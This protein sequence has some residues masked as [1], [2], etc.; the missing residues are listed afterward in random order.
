MSKKIH[1]NKFD[2][3]KSNYLGA[4]KPIT[5]TCPIHG[6][7][8]LKQSTYHISGTG[9]PKCGKKFIKS[10][11]EFIKK[12]KEIHGDKYDYSKVEYN[13]L[14]DP[15]TIICPIHGE[16]MQTPRSHIQNK[17]NCPKCSGVGKSNT[18]EFIEKSKKIHGSNYDYSKV[19]YKGNKK[20]VT[21]ICKKHGE[22]F[23]KP[24]SHLT[25]MGCP[26]CGRER[27]SDALSMNTDE[28]INSAKEIHG[29]KYDYS[30]VDYKNATTPIKIICP[31]HGEFEQVPYYHLSGNG[32]KKCGAR[33]IPYTTREYISA[34]KEIHG[35]K[36]DYSNTE[37]V[38]AQTPI[39]INCKKHGEFL[40]KPSYHL[41]GHGCPRCSESKGQSLVRQ[42]LN[43]NSVPFVEEKRFDDCTNEFEGRYCIK[44]P[45]DFYVE[46]LNTIIEY[47][48]IQHYLPSFGAK[49]FEITQRNDKLKNSYCKRKKINLIRIPYTLSP[50][51]VE[52]YLLSKLGITE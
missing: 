8:E 34:A 27:I 52:V 4:T 7:F 5:I 1:G 3:S 36:F 17:A 29:D 20:P 28:F 24:N 46:S 18:F 14:K 23:Q 48:G 51:E 9:C 41:S 44:L 19:E 10:N 47:D 22:F 37:Y 30:E 38:N 26:K 25:G 45:F 11:D 21:I 31:T 35:D 6:D 15:V 43:K 40:Q 50:E 39:K 42:I 32:C 49:S 16:F 12:G 33:N 2:Y 13:K